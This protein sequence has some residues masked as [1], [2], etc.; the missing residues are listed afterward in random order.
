MSS[1]LGFGSA[2]LL[3][4]VVAAG[5]RSPAR[6]NDYWAETLVPSRFIPIHGALLA[7]SRT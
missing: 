6:R 4:Q 7:L 2:L 3:K 1:I 5:R